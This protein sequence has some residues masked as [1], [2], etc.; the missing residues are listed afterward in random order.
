MTCFRISRGGAQEYFNVI[1]D[2]TCLGKIIGGGLPV[3]AYGGKREI[4]EMLAPAGPV[5]Q[6]G[7]LSGNP[8]A[9]SAGLTTLK[10]ID[11]TPDFHK[12][13]EE[14]SARLE[15]GFR[16]NLD[17][18][19]IQAVINRVASMM[20]VFFTDLKEVKSFD[21]ANKSDTERFKKYFHLMLQQGIYLPPSQ[22][23]AAFLTAA[24]TDE[25][26]EKTLQANKKAL[27]AL[28]N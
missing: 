18:E 22:F 6:A 14:K 25:D 2:I 15:K 24:L 8:L 4:M 5:Y 19:D 23:E 9:M 13:L 20:T 26:I 17:S 3:G 10:I 27:K 12:K 11:E 28:K 21:D 7:T 1:P 16:E